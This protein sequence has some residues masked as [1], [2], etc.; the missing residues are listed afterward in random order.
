MT[1][2]CC[3]QSLQCRGGKGAAQTMNLP[4]FVLA[5]FSAPSLAT[6]TDKSSAKRQE[7]DRKDCEEIG[8]KIL[9]VHCSCNQRKHPPIPIPKVFPAL[10]VCMGFAKW[11]P[12]TS[13][14]LPNAFD[15]PQ[16]Y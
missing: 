12:F 11:Q 2:S 6:F 14:T 4:R 9:C 16:K 13:A 10:A 7:V 1:H 15:K 3:R 5:A 8:T